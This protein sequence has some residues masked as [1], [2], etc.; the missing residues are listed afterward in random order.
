MQGGKPLIAL[1]P[2]HNTEKDEIYMRPAYLKAIQAAGGTPLVLPLDLKEEELQRLADLFDAF[3]S[4]EG[5]MFIPFISERKRDFTAEMCLS[6]GIPWNLLCLR[7]SWRRKN[8][9]WVFAGASSF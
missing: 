5:R 2:Y 7:W 4:Q 8:P 9:F 1:T 3:C 6:G